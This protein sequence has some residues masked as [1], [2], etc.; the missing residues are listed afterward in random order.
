MYGMPNSI[1]IESTAPVIYRDGVSAKVLSVCLLFCCLLLPCVSG[2]RVLTMTAV[3]SPFCRGCKKLKCK[4]LLCSTLGNTTKTRNRWESKQS[5]EKCM[6]YAAVQCQEHLSVQ[7]SRG[8]SGPSWPTCL[9]TPCICSSVP[10]LFSRTTSEWQLFAACW[11]VLSPHGSNLCKLLLNCCIEDG[12]TKPAQGG[13]GV[14]DLLFPCAFSS[15][16]S[17]SAFFCSS[18][19][20]FLF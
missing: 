11:Y 5:Q 17:S 8:T 20:F 6:C 10:S 18:L 1:T 14:L 13:C 2:V 9:C 3:V 7:D 19:H 4:Y 16:A 15:V 12:G